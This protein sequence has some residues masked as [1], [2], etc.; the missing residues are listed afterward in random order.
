MM[1][2]TGRTFAP[3]PRNGL[4]SAT[5][6]NPNAGT[7]SDLNCPTSCFV[8]GNV[9]DMSILGQE[10]WPCHNVC[11][12]GTVWDTSGLVCS[13][14]PAVP[15]P[16]VPT[17]QN[18]QPPPTPVDCTQVWNQYFSDQCGGSSTAL[19]VGGL[20]IAAIIAVVIASKV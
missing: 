10:C 4:G 11:P 1:R 12:P 3:R 9:L 5:Q 16:V 17:T 7:Y 18:D 20:A 8:L 15:N 13:S 2:Y 14:N 19:Y 6:A